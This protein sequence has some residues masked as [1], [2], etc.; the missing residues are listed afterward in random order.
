MLT[1]LYYNGDITELLTWQL[2]STKQKKFK[3]SPEN[4]H[5]FV[6]EMRCPENVHLLMYL[7]LCSQHSVYFVDWSVKYMISNLCNTQP[8]RT[9]NFKWWQSYIFLMRYFS[10]KSKVN[11]T[12]RSW[13]MFIDCNLMNRVYNMT[14][15]ANMKQVSFNFFHKGV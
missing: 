8:G 2:L 4:E 7:K 15:V 14:G 9:A 1:L 11:T 6:S 5:F 10:S 3:F 13:D 12:C